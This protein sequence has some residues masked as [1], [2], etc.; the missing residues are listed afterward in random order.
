MVGNFMSTVRKQK[1]EFLRVFLGSFSP[2]PPSPPSPPVPHPEM[3]FP[4]VKMDLPTPINVAEKIPQMPSQRVTL[5]W[6]ISHRCA[7]SRVS[8][9]IL[10]R[11]VEAEGQK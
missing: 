10:G 3:V 11:T 8:W 2:P 1:C 5:A 6:T 4:I 7:L 9:V